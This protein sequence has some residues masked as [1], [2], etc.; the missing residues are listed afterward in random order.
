MKPSIHEGFKALC[1]RLRSA[2]IEPQVIDS[3]GVFCLLANSCAI[4]HAVACGISSTEV[5]QLAEP[6]ERA[7]APGLRKHGTCEAA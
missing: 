3:L 6:I 1:E 2:S 4:W 5:A 7:D